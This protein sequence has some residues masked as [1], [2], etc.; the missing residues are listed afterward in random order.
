MMEYNIVFKE[1]EKVMPYK[2]VGRDRE[3]KR[4]V[5]KIVYEHFSELIYT[6]LTLGTG[7]V[8]YRWFEQGLIIELY[9]KSKDGKWKS[10][11]KL[12]KQ[13][14]KHSCYDCKHICFDKKQGS[15][16]QCNNPKL[17]DTRDCYFRTGWAK[18]EKK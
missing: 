18:W 13:R 10:A 2:L 7:G 6:A 17:E 3:T 1:G 12:L 5:N 11:N 15:S 14:F 4:Q 8:A 16:I 9:H